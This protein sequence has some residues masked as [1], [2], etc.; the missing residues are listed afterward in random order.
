M[1]GTARELL[2][3]LTDCEQ[4]KK[5]T[6]KSEVGERHFRVE[7]AR[8]RVES[9]VVLLQREEFTDDGDVTC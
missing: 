7:C 8:A 3:S 9:V 5:K 1:D 6:Y 2:I 4:D